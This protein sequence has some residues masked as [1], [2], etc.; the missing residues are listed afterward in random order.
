MLGCGKAT[1]PISIESSW[2]NERRNPEVRRGRACGT[3]WGESERRRFSV[4]L[5]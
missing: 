5:K 1:R 4:G 2:T 3:R